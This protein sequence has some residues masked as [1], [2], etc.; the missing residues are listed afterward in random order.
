MRRNWFLLLTMGFGFAF[1]YVPILLLMIYS[2]NE[3]R[4]VTV[5]AGF[6]AKWYGAL[7]RDEQMLGA[8]W[9]SFRI[10]VVNASLATILGTLAALA[11][12]RFGR[13]RGRTLFSGMLSAPLVMP[14]VITG[15]ASLLLFVA[16]EQLLGW[17]QGRGMTTITIAHIT[18][19]TA[20]V[21]VVLQSRLQGMDRSIEEAAMDLGARPAKVFLLI[22]IPVI[23]PA[24]VA[25]WLLSFT[26]SLDDLVIAS[27]VSGP[28][29]S[30]LP[31]VVFSSVRLGVSPEINA[32]ATILVLTATVAILI[33]GWM[34][35]RQER[36]SQKLTEKREQQM[37]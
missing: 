16:L 17:P 6:S 23:A 31:M 37:G 20:Y 7:L 11:M 34:M 28:A 2:F 15:L 4:L 8:A 18:F 30:T 29:S 5:W 10:A 35:T 22:T 19:S 14:E 33:A 9:M 26:L 24:L 3:S 21:A 32:L 13:F 1:L 25:G 27:F 36:A 12:V